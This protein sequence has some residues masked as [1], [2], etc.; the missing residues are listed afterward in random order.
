[1]SL[2]S[3]AALLLLP[4]LVFTSCGGTDPDAPQLAS[5]TR[6]GENAAQALFNKGFAFEQ[7]G[8][9]GKA[10]NEYEDIG[11]K[12]KLATVAAD[13][14]YRRARLLE[15]DGD[16]LAAFE[17]Y[18]ELLQN[19]PASSH[20]ATAITRQEDIAHRAAQ[21]A[22][23][24]SF[25]GIKSRIDVRKSAEMLTK[26]REN[27]PRSLAAE[28]AQFT[29]GKVLESDKKSKEAIAAFQKVVSD[30]P[31][32]SYSP[33][34][35]YRIGTILMN[36]SRGGNQDT[37]N[38]DR[39]RN[40]FDD[41]LIR[42]P[43]SARAKDAKAA[44]ARISSGNIKRSFDVAEFYRKKGQNAS[45]LF[46]YREAVRTSQPGPIHNQ[47]KAWIEKLSS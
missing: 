41:V 39:A 5:K 20:Y 33:E 17:A 25:I 18:N 7:A 3:K 24:R 46:Y 34:A 44:L 6:A 12:Y 47:A 27:A 42:Y 11:K 21:G 26:V 16:P 29:I 19:Y 13:A 8:K 32:S 40:A 37:A 36:E 9:R 30:F 35:Q 2:L 38:L 15:A 45:A 22:I 14:T 4:I 23:K 43:N 1:M 10:I 28:K 31:N